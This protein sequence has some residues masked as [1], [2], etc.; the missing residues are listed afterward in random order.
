M[1][2][3]GGLCAAHTRKATILQGGLQVTCGT[4]PDEQHQHA[5]AA[6]RTVLLFSRLAGDTAYV[7]FEA[8]AEALG[9]LLR[10]DVLTQ[11]AATLPAAFVAMRRF[12]AGGTAANHRPAGLPCIEHAKSAESAASMCERYLGWV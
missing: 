12:R 5:F 4:D 1:C 11:R 8:A 6:P 7:V 9:L 10:V 2:Q 3:L